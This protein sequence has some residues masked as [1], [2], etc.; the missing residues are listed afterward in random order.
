MFNTGDLLSRLEGWYISQCN[1]VW[2]H[3]ERIKLSTVD[4]PGWTLEV[5]LVET[6]WANRA[7]SRM[8]IDRSEHNWLHCWVE[9]EKFFAAGGP[10]NLREMIET[11]LWFVDPFY[12][13]SSEAPSLSTLNTKPL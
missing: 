8:Q 13:Q 5:N 1:G 11:F 4:N 6:E 7:F 2:E 3:E 9:A 12:N 10:L